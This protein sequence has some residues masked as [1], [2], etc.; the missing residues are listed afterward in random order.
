MLGVCDECKDVL[1][2]DQDE[3]SGPWSFARRLYV[4]VI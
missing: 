1:N 3:A 4:P 2:A